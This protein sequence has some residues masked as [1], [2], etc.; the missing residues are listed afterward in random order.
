MEFAIMYTYT[1]TERCVRL[2]EILSSEYI[3]FTQATAIELV[4]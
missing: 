1:D 3:F 2:R 4:V